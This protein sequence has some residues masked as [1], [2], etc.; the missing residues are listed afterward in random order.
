[1]ESKITLSGVMSALITPFYQGKIDF[2]TYEKLLLRQIRYG[3][4]ACVPVGT[5]GESATLNHK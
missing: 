5:T 3:M 1:M 4:D 2:N